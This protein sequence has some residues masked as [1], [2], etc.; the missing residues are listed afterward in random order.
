VNTG[1][2]LVEWTGGLLRS[3]LYCVITAPGEQVSLLRRSV[4]YLVQL[5]NSA[6]MR[7]LKGGRIP[8]VKE[9]EEETR[10]VNEWAAWRSKQ[11]MLGHLKP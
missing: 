9:D 8:P 5:A 11:I 10:P 2:T 3:L 4:A 1:D 7:R 6:S